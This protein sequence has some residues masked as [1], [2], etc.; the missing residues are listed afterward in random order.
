MQN[1]LHFSVSL[2]RTRD[3]KKKNL[4]ELIRKFKSVFHHNIDIT[5]TNQSDYKL[6]IIS[7]NAKGLNTPVK[8]RMAY[9]NYLAHHADII[10]IQ[11]THFKKGR[12]PK[13]LHPHLTRCY[14]SSATNKTRG[15]AI[16]IRESCPL[17]VHT[18]HMDREGRI[19]LLQAQLNDKPIT[20]VG[21]YAPNTKQSRFFSHLNNFVTNKKSGDLVVTTDF[22]N[23]LDVKLDCSSH[24]RDRGT[25]RANRALI[26]F[27]KD[28]Y[29]FDIWRNLN[30]KQK[31]FT[32][33]SSPHKS[34]SRIDLILISGTYLPYL[35]DSSIEPKT[36]S[37]HSPILGTLLIPQLQASRG[38][39]RLNES[40]LS[41]DTFCK[42][43]YKQINYYFKENCQ[44]K[45]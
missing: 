37:D 14:Y 4:L 41:D 42:D 35:Y 22:N 16:L 26:Q 25:G 8:W 1:V 23:V 39:W 43:L 3:G 30:P 19:L 29:L 5:M 31:D 9:K 33:Y 36:W 6:T 11:E 27:L 10:V 13:F 34:Y 17:V 45:Q 2:S 44:T 20:I 21:I 40:L 32:F 28:E 38:K 15:V 18:S 7:H 12:E 24:R